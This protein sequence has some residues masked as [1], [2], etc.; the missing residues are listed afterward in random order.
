MTTKTCKIQEITTDKK[1]TKTVTVTQMVPRHS[2]IRWYPDTHTSDGTQTLAH[3][4]KQM[5]TTP[6]KSTKH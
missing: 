3:I 2:H 5:Q 1:T 4:F 6:I